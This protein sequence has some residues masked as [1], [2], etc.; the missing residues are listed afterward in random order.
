MLSRQSLGSLALA[1][2]ALSS[3]A[4]AQ[5]DGNGPNA[6]LRMQS[7]TPSAANSATHDV[8][9]GTPG[10]FT[11]DIDSGANPTAGIVMAVSTF[12]PNT[13][14]APV[15]TGAGFGAPYLHVDLGQPGL[16]LGASVVL[17]ADG[18]ALSSNPLLDIF[19]ITSASA[20]HTFRQAFTAG[21]HLC[22]GRLAWQAF[23]L[24]FSQF[25]LPYDNTELGDS[26]F[27]SGQEQILLTNSDGTVNVPF[28]P[29]H[30]F[31]F[32]GANYT[33]VWVE[34]N[35]FI[36]FGAQ[37][38]TGFS[39]VIVDV[40]YWAQ[41]QPSI[42]AAMV[43][44][45]VTGSFG[46]NPNDGV[47]FN[48]LGGSVLI[49]WGDPRGLPS[50]ATGIPHGGDTDINRFDINLEL[51][52]DT[53]LDP[54]SVANPNDGTFTLN[55]PFF[56]A[57]TI[58]WAGSGIFG[59]TPGTQNIGA[60]GNSLNTASLADMDL[61]GQFNIT[62][63]ANGLG[64]A[65]IEE[66]NRNNSNSSVLSRPGASGAVYNEL[67]SASG[68]S[69]T[70]LPNP[71]IVGP[72]DSGYTS[73]ATGTP[74]DDVIGTDVQ[75]FG[76]TPSTVI[77]IA[78]K[79]FGLAGSAA[80]TVTFTDS[81][82]IPY[83]VNGPFSVVPAGTIGASGAHNGLF[84][85]TNEG[86]LVNTPVGMTTGLC[87]V[88]IAFGASGYSKSFS[89]Y[90]VGPGQTLATYSMTDDDSVPHTFSNGLTVQFYGQTYSTIYVGSNGY[91]TF[92]TQTY[93]CCG[94]TI[95]ELFAG[96]YN[97]N[98]AAVAVW[99]DYN[100]G[101]PGAGIY[102]VIEDT[103]QNTVD[104]QFSNM[105]Y[106]GTGQPAG[107]FLIHFDAG[108][109]DSGF[110]DFSGLNTTSSGLHPTIVGLAP[111]DPNLA[112]VGAIPPM[113][114]VTADVGVAESFQST[115]PFGELDISTSAYRRLSWQIIAGAPIGTGTMLLF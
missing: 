16:P 46:V 112:N 36:N 87:N 64:D 94:G 92:G 70:F 91:V 29:G 12:D 30:S 105:V 45:D 17:V 47:Y 111:G 41:Q 69:I 61:Q 97:Q 89:L 4:A 28:L 96:F 67:R 49:S 79:F 39:S 58:N 38:T 11:I 31:N 21:Q 7:Q 78:G 106:Y 68:N 71:W 109:A 13:A 56:D 82:Q 2:V 44:W 95:G 3:L 15:F 25:P 99:N 85:R 98:N 32:H 10:L 81:T 37:G 60:G 1:I 65:M 86:I 27:I 6:S 5:F 9:V 62:T 33:D 53:L 48:E 101:Y 24:D 77:T 34:G 103:V 18:I 51:A 26:N 55:Y 90:V 114:A 115:G 84:F 102:T 59:H 72:G 19:Y 42:A 63:G 52:V 83:V 75:S 40:Q 80:D 8:S 104:V 73:F 54:C 57:N 100:P 74:V 23:V 66:H 22:G 14:T 113:P 110:V 108:V 93:S 76:T 50:G 107:T 35:G 88:T 43:D 20:P